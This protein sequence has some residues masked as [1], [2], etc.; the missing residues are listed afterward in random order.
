MK[1]WKFKIQKELEM[2]RKMAKLSGSLDPKNMQQYGA[3]EMSKI[4]DYIQEEFQMDMTH[5]LDGVKKYDILKE[6]EIVSLTK[7]ITTQL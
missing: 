7:I 3:I 5:V 4:A 6:Q 1:I 2:H